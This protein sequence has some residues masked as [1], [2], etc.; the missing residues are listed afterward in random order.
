M[1]R[2]GYD[3]AKL[4]YW[5]EYMDRGDM[6]QFLET[7]PSG[8]DLP[9]LALYLG[10]NILEGLSYLH[11]KNIVHRDLK[12][13]N[14]LLTTARLSVSSPEIHLVAKIAGLCTPYCNFDVLIYPPIDFGTAHDFKL[15][16]TI[17]GLKG[18][19]RCTLPSSYFH[20]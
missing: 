17:S 7:R 1:R 3:L 16:G 8:I 15:H 10:C 9:K 5:M 19:P 2:L 11:S 6:Q 12:P 14:I 4:E 20:L 13:A 18:T